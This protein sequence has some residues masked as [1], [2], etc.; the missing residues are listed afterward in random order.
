MSLQAKE[1]TCM[2]RKNAYYHS[3]TKACGTEKADYL[4]P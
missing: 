3:A 1:M 4:D 2:R